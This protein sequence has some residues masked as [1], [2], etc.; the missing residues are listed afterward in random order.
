MN[1][2]SIYALRD[3]KTELKI[4]LF[5]F[6]NLVFKFRFAILCKNH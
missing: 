1:A 2:I 3:L 4:T 5:I 6:V